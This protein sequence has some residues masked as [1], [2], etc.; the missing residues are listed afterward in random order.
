MY[1][2]IGNEVSIPLK[3]IVAFFDLDQC[4][5]E[6]DELTKEFLSINDKKNLI[7]VI[8]GDIP[9]TIII[10]LE[11]IYLSPLSSD[12]LYERISKNMYKS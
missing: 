6:K 3:M 12:T 9:R 8:N 7:E 2:N 1:V 5:G 4:T 10:T 11:N